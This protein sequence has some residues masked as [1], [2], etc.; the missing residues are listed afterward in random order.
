MPHSILLYCMYSCWY[1]SGA[2]V[3]AS[4][5]IP[6]LNNHFKVNGGF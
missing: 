3:Y 5:D 2:V 1:K 4:K 6:G